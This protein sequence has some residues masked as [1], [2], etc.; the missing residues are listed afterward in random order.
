MSAAT[1]MATMPALTADMTDALPADPALD[2]LAGFYVSEA[3][4]HLAA[5]ELQFTHDLQPAQLALLRPTDAAPALFSRLARHWLRPSRTPPRLWKWAGDRWLMGGLGALCGGFVAMGLFIADIDTGWLQTHQ[6][7]LPL[8][9]LAVL[10]GALVGCGVAVRQ[11]QKAPVRRFERQVR[12][13]LELGLWALVLHDVPFASQAK[14]A[15][16]VC[17]RSVRWCAVALPVDRP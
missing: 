15:A 16:M 5:R 7:H 9:L 12:H 11:R 10:V 3:E 1:F 14:V 17:S 13:G 4:W 6:L 2:C 8:M